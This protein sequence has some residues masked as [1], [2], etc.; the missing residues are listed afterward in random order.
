MASTVD[1]KSA[2]NIK[3][4]K[5]HDAA[6][7][8]IV[9][10]ASFVV[11]YLYDTRKGAWSKTGIEGPMFLYHRTQAPHYGMFLL[12]RNGVDNFSVPLTKDDDLELTEEFVILRTEDATSLG[13]EDDEED[14]EKIIG[15]WVFEKD[16][17]QVV[18][19]EMLR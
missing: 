17:R 13:E 7:D 9:H 18:G 19:N 14:D 8:S 5:R 4:L 2:F 15:V 12:N 3:V 16:Q 11:L 10:S 1:V 6:I